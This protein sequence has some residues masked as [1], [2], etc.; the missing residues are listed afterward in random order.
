M[1]SN[2][3]EFDLLNKLA[4]KIANH[5]DCRGYGYTL[6]KDGKKLLCE[7]R[8]ESMYEFRLFK[9]GIPPKFRK[10]SFKDYSQKSSNTF[11]KVQDYIKNF[12]TH[13]TEGMGLY[14]HGPSFTG[15]S[16]LACSVLMELM[17]NGYDC[18]YEAFDRLLDDHNYDLNRRA[19][20]EWDL[21]CLE[22]GINVVDRLTNFRAA[23]LS[24]SPTHGALEY[25][26]SI[27]S[28]RSNAGRPTLITGNVS[29]T[30]LTAQV[31]ELANTMIGN[32]I[33]IEC[34]DKGFRK[35]RIEQMMTD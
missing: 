23:N 14:L 19:D 5:A 27:L 4:D 31:P 29:L 35:Q 8:R 32:C 22:R 30:D 24:G 11:H 10:M 25:L 6:G 2:P 15:K 9:S 21:L 1:D 26:N 34:E 16:L 28:R 12:A 20:T 13:R 7:C 3:S 18:R 17:R 33:Q